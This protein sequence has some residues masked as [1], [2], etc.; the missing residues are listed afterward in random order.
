MYTCML[1]GKIH[2]ATVTD[3]SVEY[4]GSLTIDPDLMA[5]ANIVAYEKVAVWSLTSGERLETYAIPGEAGS[6]EICANG[7]AALRIKRGE[8]VIIA[9]FVWLDDCE[10]PQHQPHRVFVDE[11]NHISRHRV[12]P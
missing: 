3:A 11:H 4:E 12:G 1:K 2:G 9:A 6:G 5:A 8:K 10:S 7:A